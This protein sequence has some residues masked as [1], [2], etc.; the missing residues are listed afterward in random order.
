MFLLYP[1]YISIYNCVTVLY[2]VSQD[3]CYKR[4]DGLKEINFNL[5][6]KD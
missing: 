3:C 5:T 2:S 6:L 4:C 1:R